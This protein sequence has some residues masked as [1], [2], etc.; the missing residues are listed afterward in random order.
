MI[1][2]GVLVPGWNL[3]A[4]S[5]SGGVPTALLACIGVAVSGWQLR[6]A[7]ERGSLGLSS[8]TLLFAVWLCMA[9]TTVAALV[10]FGPQ[11]TTFCLPVAFG[12]TGIVV[13]LALGRKWCSHVLSAVGCLY[14][15]WAISRYATGQGQ[16]W[17]GTVPRLDG[18]GDGPLQGGF[19]LGAFALVAL[20]L[21]SHYG[22]SA[23]PLLR[24]ASRSI[25]AV[26]AFLTFSRGAILALLLGWA[27]WH[28]CSRRNWYG[29]TLAV[30]LVALAFGVRGCGRENLQHS[31]KAG[32]SRITIWCDA[33]SWTWQKGVFG[34]GVG[35][36]SYYYFETK[37]RI[38]SD[39]ALPEPK[40]LPLLI[41]SQFGLPGLVIV[42]S[43]A[44]AAASLS[45]R[46]WRRGN[47]FPAAAVTFVVAAGVFDTVAMTPW[48]VKSTLVLGM[49]T[50]LMAQSADAPGTLQKTDTTDALIGPEERGAVE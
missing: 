22:L 15:V 27:T 38:T 3:V 50:V 19:L 4:W 26:A 47:G 14:S 28:R 21:G 46:E 17:S 13:G 7:Q 20:D 6:T 32:L 49:L 23:F 18:I 16:W 31:T 44:V 11:A 36:Y 30:F 29:V 25:S 35:E 33:L 5:E 34:G 39:Q 43:W 41:L 8:L 1:A 48:S 40:S 10:G 2:A 24:W 9:L 45:L 42:A 12:A 37:D